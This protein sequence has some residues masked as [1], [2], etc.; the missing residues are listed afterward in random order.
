MFIKFRA[1]FLYI[2]RG[3]IV[4]FIYKKAGIEDLDMLVKTRIEILKVINHIDDNTDMSD[5]EKS[6]LDYYKEALKN[7]THTAYLV[8]DNDKF[9]GAGGIDYYKVMPSYHNPSGNTAFIMNIY[10][11]P[12]Y[13]RKGIAYKVLDLLVKDAKERGVENIILDSTLM[14]RPL[15]E[16]YGFVKIND[17]MELPPEK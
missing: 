11:N 16:K 8:F 1:V 13:R 14:G 3:G 6:T 9:I 4:N 17:Y 7:N 15:Y 5:F 2:I 10:T 12:D